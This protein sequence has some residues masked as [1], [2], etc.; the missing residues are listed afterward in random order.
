MAGMCA[1]PP[2]REHCGAFVRLEHLAADLA[3]VEARLGLSLAAAMPRAN[4]SD[5]PRDWRAAHDAGTAALVA[6]DCAEDIAR[7]G[8]RFDP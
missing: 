4:A 3:P 6:E 5:R 2:G 1:C 8:Y 7:F